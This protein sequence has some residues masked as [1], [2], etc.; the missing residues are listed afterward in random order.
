MPGSIEDAQW[1]FSMVPPGQRGASLQEGCRELFLETRLVCIEYDG[2]NLT[3]KQ[4]VLQVLNL[5]LS[6][7]HQLIRVSGPPKQFRS[8]LQPLV[9]GI[10]L[11]CRIPYSYRRI[12]VFHTPQRGRRA[13]AVISTGPFGCRPSQ[14]LSPSRTH[15]LLSH[16]LVRYG[17]H[18]GR[19]SV[20]RTRN[21]NAARS[22]ACSTPT[23]PNTC[24]GGSLPWPSCVP[25]HR[26]HRLLA[27]QSFSWARYWPLQCCT[28]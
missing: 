18:L 6:H 3:Q 28:C 13:L 25:R 23:H 8:S 27:G 20:H 15:P 21:T 24:F 9:G 17:Q 22:L 11:A 16:P 14:R 7:P 26:S 5:V 4:E 1:W 19:R 10:E 12:Y 2:L